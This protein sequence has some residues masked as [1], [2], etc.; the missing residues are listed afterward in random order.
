MNL[1]P[2]QKLT[3]S[4]A[5]YLKYHTVECGYLGRNCGPSVG[6]WSICN[7][8]ETSCFFYVYNTGLITDILLSMDDRFLYFSNWLHGDLRQYDITDSR[9][10]K[11][12][13]Q[14]S[15]KTNYI[16]C[17]LQAGHVRMSFSRSVDK[18]GQQ[19]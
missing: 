2:K 5:R 9:N 14:V 7:F 12:V 1:Y 18:F 19:K 16:M 8:R 15:C 3:F 13:G 11:L 10:P 17:Y 4:D 6:T